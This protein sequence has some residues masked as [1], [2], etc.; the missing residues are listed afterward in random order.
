LNCSRIFQSKKHES[1]L[2]LAHA[3][4]IGLSQEYHNHSNA[5]LGVQLG[6]NYAN[7]YYADFSAAVPHSAKLPAGNRRAISPTLSLSWRLSEEPFLQQS[8]FHDLR[9]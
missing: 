3:I 7:K 2:L 4:Q 5:N 1:A 6:Y 8:I 9:L